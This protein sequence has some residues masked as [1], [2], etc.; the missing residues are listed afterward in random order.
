[1]DSINNGEVKRCNV[2]LEPTLDVHRGRI[3]QEDSCL[4]DY[5]PKSYGPVVDIASPARILSSATLE[6]LVKLMLDVK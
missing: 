6:V 3:R 4:Q 1:M 2:T 5:D